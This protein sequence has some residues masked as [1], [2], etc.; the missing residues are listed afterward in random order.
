MPV[1]REQTLY[2]IG[3]AHIDPVWLWQ[4]PEGREEMLS[5]C[6]TALQLMDE[7]E[8]F[9]FCRASAAELAW[10][11]EYDPELFARI[12]ERVAEGRFVIVGG[13]WVQPDCNV[14]C[15]EAFV[16]H[17]LYGKAWIRDRFG[18]DVRVG[19]NVDT[20]GHPATL[21]Q[22]LA[23]AGLEYYCFFR[24]GPHEKQLPGPLF[25]WQAPDGTEVLACRAPGHYGT[26]PQDIED[27]IRECAAGIPEPLDGMLCF[28][29]VGNHGGGP[30]RQNLACIHQLEGD[31]SLP[32]LLVSGP[33]RFFTQ[34]ERHRPALPI[35]RDELQYHAR[36][37]YTAVS[38]VKR[39]NRQVEQLLMTAE[40]MTSVAWALGLLEPSSAELAEGWKMLLFNQFHDILA[41]TS[42]RTAYDDCR[43]DYAEAKL[44]AGRWLRKALHRLAASAN[45][46]GDGQPIVVFNPT[47]GDRTEVIEMDVAYRGS[48]G[49]TC[50]LGDRGEE[51]PALVLEPTVHTSGRTHTVAFKAE[52]PSLGYRVYRLVNKA[53]D[54]VFP[55]VEV[56]PSSLE[57]RRFRVEL[58]PET[59][60]IT[61]LVDKQ[62]AVELC[63]GPCNVPLVMNDPSDTWSHEIAAFREEVGAFRLTREPEV[64]Q[65]G[66]T[67]GILRLVLGF[68]TS[69]IEQYIV[70]YQDIPEIAFRTAVDWHQRHQMLKMAFPTAVRDATA[71]F[72]VAYGHITRS[73]TGDEQ[74]HHRWM[75]LTGNVGGH[76]YGLAVINDGKYG[77]DVLGGEMR[78]SV[79]RSPIYAFHDPQKPQ[80][81]ENYEYV[82]HGLQTFTYGLLPHEGDWRDAGVVARAAALNAPC[83]C[84]VEPPHRGTLPSRQSFLSVTGRNVSLD[85]LKRA[86]DGD[87]LVLRGYETAGRPERIEPSLLGAP[88]GGLDFGPFEIKSWRLRRAGGGWALSECDLLE[89]EL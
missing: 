9:V 78:L 2:L 75:D 83:L 38:E 14:P 27:R 32:R 88:L 57:S 19:Y 13:W 43:A 67:H 1:S 51:V 68:E 59:G 53:P 82:D 12:R 30:T 86:E 26:G 54:V 85:V 48:R 10:V 46:S 17:A 33:E 6:R 74:P 23:K 69:V 5:T 21:P 34:A 60:W 77:C 84:L 50:I 66:A 49:E 29:G 58:D 70:L 7:D 61:S 80:P 81:D 36:G 42:I 4:W 64:L 41:G 28:F 31:T 39:D 11:E 18:V 16:R 73:A 45:T 24:P 62:A 3:N 79:L 25:R 65:E 35:V 47:A 37:C 89:R 40:R 87:G 76:A 22:I 44:L 15:G 71:T 55:G 52:L 56:A 8:A 20:F 63:A 72:E